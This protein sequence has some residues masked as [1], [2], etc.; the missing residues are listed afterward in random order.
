MKGS[1]WTLWNG[2]NPIALQ[3]L[4]PL[5]FKLRPL[6][7][8]SWDPIWSFFF[9][10][11]FL[12]LCS[13]SCPEFLPC[14]SFPTCCPAS[15]EVLFILTTPPITLLH[16]NNLNLTTLFLLCQLRNFS[17]LLR[18]MTHLLESSNDLH[19][20]PLGNIDFPL[21]TDGSI[22]NVTMANTVLGIPLKRLHLLI[23]LRQHL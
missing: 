16:F 15:Y 12:I 22:Q 9:F 19:E 21:L 2:C 4:L 10:F 13:G 23:L 3:P 5:P 20:I 18:L 14:W 8:S 7:K 1:I 6:R 11:L 17:C